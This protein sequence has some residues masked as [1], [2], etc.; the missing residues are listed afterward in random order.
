MAP[1][2][3]SN[4]LVWL[5]I[6]GAAICLIGICCFGLIFWNTGEPTSTLTPT[7]NS[8]P[9]LIILTAH[10]AAT[11]TQSVIMPTTVITS[12]FS[13]TLTHPA[14][15][16]PIDT[17]IPTNTVIFILPTLPASSGGT[18]SCSGDNYK[19]ED[20]STHIEAQRCFDYC[21][22]QGAGDIHRLDQDNDGDACEG[23][24]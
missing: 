12:T 8:I 11:Q 17:A 2:R 10:A 20:F 23:L 14:I 7:T 13:P 9:T 5:F 22:S 1:K 21:I 24:P 18:C 6:S 15:S 4:S 3:K 19:C 16:T